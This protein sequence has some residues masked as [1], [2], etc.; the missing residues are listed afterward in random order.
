MQP[1]PWPPNLTPNSLM[2]WSMKGISTAT[3]PVRC[4]GVSLRIV[5]SC[6]LPTSTRDRYFNTCQDYVSS[7]SLRMLSYSL[8]Q[9]PVPFGWRDNWHW[10][11]CGEPWSSWLSS[12]VYANIH[13]FMQKDPRKGELLITHRSPKDPAIDFASHFR[14]SLLE[15]AVRQCRITS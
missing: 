14:S 10:T 7:A 12:L 4:S 6:L 1:Q 5:P 13:P 15:I 3:F 11:S 8:S 2:R 9:I